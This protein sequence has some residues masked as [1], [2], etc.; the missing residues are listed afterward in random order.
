MPRKTTQTTPSA[1][2]KKSLPKSVLNP[3]EQAINSL[4]EVLTE[5]KT[6]LFDGDFGGNGECY[7]Y[8]TADRIKAAEIILK[9]APDKSPLPNNH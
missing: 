5:T 6:D 2:S 3:T 8:S 7:V 4:L 9:Y 1:K